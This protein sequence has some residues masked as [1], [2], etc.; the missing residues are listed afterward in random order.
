[1]VN[2]SAR[3]RR[4]IWTCTWLVLLASPLAVAGSG[5]DGGKVELVLYYE[6]LCPYCSNFI[7]NH[8]AKAF[9]SSLISILDLKLVPYGNARI[10]ANDTI[11]CQVRFRFVPPSFRFCFCP[12]GLRKPVDLP[13]L[14][15]ERS[16]HPH[17][18]RCMSPTPRVQAPP[19]H[20]HSIT[21]PP[22]FSLPRSST[23]TW[24]EEIEPRSSLQSSNN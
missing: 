7:V 21:P 1:M 17:R 3:L 9:D 10:G 5:G 13:L 16:S 6:T 22:S 11:T 18:H 2:Q 23:K 4:A 24:S 14:V 15:T 20:H 19:L 12:S 8:L